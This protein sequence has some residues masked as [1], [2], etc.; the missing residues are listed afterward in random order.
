LVGRQPTKRD[1]GV[2]GEL[3]HFRP[4][5]I[6]T[7]LIF[8]RMSLELK[9]DFR[10]TSVMP[11]SWSQAMLAFHYCLGAIVALAPAGLQDP[12]A[13]PPATPP[14]S[15][16]VESAAIVDHAGFFS[17]PAL[18]AALARLERFMNAVQDRYVYIETYPRVPDE[19]QAALESQGREKVFEGWAQERLGARRGP[20][21]LVLICREPS[22]L[23][24]EVS[25]NLTQFTR[26]H[27]LRVRDIILEDFQ[28]QDY[29]RALERAV[30][31]AVNT[32]RVTPTMG[33]TL[34]GIRLDPSIAAQLQQMREERAAAESGQNQWLL[35]V[36]IILGAVLLWLLIGLFRA[37]ARPQAPPTYAG[38]H[39]DLAAGFAGY[40]AAPKTSSFAG[41]LLVGLFG[42]AAGR[43]LYRQLL[44]SQ[45]PAWPMDQGPTQ[46]SASA[47]ANEQVLHSADG[48][49]DAAG[50][51]P[52]GNG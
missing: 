51:T 29:D 24:V 30:A 52:R 1:L 14:G 19:L 42:A 9:R 48:G 25:P 45:A 39:A 15:S 20:A 22:R 2:G 47:E 49:Y 44:R 27:S 26:Q 33:A 8:G 3:A 46:E 31:Y 17:E 28:R 11:T 23:H 21:V 16:A 35:W 6:E 41:N 5:D 43:Y 10:R 4:T 50:P 13:T 36:A 40:P 32:L 18:K 34:R 37:L 38:G 7:R 12:A